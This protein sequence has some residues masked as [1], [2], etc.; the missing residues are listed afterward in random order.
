RRYTRSHLTC[1]GLH[2]TPLH[3]G[4]SSGLKSRSRIW[5]SSSLRDLS[6]GT[7]CVSRAGS[8]TLRDDNPNSR[9]DPTRG[10]LC[11]PPRSGSVT[12]RIGTGAARSEAM[13][14]H[15]GALR[16]AAAALLAIG[17]SGAAHAAELEAYAGAVGGQIHG[18]GGFACQTS[19]ST[20]P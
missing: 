5:P 3:A 8:S 18:P 14:F 17:F 2:P 13:R 7:G 19:G 20:I 12:A 16:G 4:S 9:P 6:S 11:W 1:S 10:P 15:D